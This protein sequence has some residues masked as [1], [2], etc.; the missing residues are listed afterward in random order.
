[1]QENE[2]IFM[3]EARVIQE[4]RGL[5]FVTNSCLFAIKVCPSVI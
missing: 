2:A 1:M 3:N 5:Y 4:A